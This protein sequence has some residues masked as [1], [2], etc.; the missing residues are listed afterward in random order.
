MNP[1][2][3]SKINCQPLPSTTLSHWVLMKQIADL[4]S[5]HCTHLDSDKHKVPPRL[6]SPTS[7]V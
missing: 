6:S 2:S 4:V 1:L 7:K 3:G 5:F